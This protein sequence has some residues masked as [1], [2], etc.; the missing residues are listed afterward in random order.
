M[1]LSQKNGVY[2]VYQQKNALIIVIN[3]L[4]GICKM[5]EHNT[6]N[7]VKLNDKTK[8]IKAVYSPQLPVKNV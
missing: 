4:I 8:R 6:L 3:L 5:Y 2:T 1:Q 7:G